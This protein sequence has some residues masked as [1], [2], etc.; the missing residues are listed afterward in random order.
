[1]E[2]GLA[3]SQR[4]TCYLK[5]MTS[6]LIDLLPLSPAG[7]HNDKG[8]CQDLIA[9]IT[10]WRIPARPARPSGRW[11]GTVVRREDV[12]YSGHGSLSRSYAHSA[13]RRLSV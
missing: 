8:G 4:S 7:N 6:G 13:R 12:D 3:N 10:T 11:P 9:R 2:F 1:V 5:S